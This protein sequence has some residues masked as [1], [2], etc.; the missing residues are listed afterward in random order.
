MIPHSILDIRDYISQAHDTPFIEMADVLR[1][2][3]KI[4]EETLNLSAKLLVRAYVRR[5]LADLQ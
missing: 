3:P 2:N 1:F 4:T 5:L